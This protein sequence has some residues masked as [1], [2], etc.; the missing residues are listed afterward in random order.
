MS[1][2]RRLGVTF[3]VRREDG[4]KQDCRASLRLENEKKRRNKEKKEYKC[5]PFLHS[6]RINMSNVNSG[7]RFD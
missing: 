2:T 4:E 1:Q 7:N 3:D 5:S 6:L